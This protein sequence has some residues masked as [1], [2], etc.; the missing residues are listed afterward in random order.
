MQ[1]ILDNGQKSDWF[2][3]VWVCETTAISL[4]SMILF[5]MWEFYFK[6]SIIDLK[7]FRDRNF[8][9]GIIL[10]TLNN[11]ILYSSLA[12]LPPFLQNLLGY[13]AFNSG[14]VIMPR[15]LGCFITIG[16]AG[17]IS[18]K[19]DNRIMAIIGYIMLATSCFMFGNL[20]LEISTSNIVL[21]NLI[22]GLAL[23]FIMIPLFNLSFATLSKEKINN[24]SGLFNL[25]RN[26][27]GGIG[28]SVVSTLLARSSQIHQANMISNLTPLNPVFA[29][30]NLAMQNFFALYM[31]Q[32]EATNKAS[33]YIY[34]LLLKQA[35]LW[36]YIDNFRL[37]CILCFAFIPMLFMFKKRKIR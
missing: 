26:I 18:S 36:S 6:D 9:V 1:I 37:Y 24:A 31:N 12:I 15:G 10:S 34:H 25:M 19:V 4:I 17:Y 11:G 22:C 32:T 28:V 35:A 5:F 33:V 23:G 29:Q 7:V 30:R 3:S 13:T 8:L 21:P 27:G 14:M 16:F 2:E 20:N